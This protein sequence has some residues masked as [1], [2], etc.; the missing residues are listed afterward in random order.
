MDNI[1]RIYNP[2]QLKIILQ[3]SFEKFEGSE[4]T[5]VYLFFCL[6]KCYLINLQNFMW[7][8]SSFIN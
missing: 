6:T 7:L 8:F 4:I 3:G 1:N 5:Q 2:M